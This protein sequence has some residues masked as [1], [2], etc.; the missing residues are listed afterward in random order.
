MVGGCVRDHLMG[1]PLY[2]W[3]IEV[4]GLAS[5]SLQDLLA[6]SGRVSLVGKSFGVF[7]WR[8]PRWRGPEIDV[9]IPRRDSKVGPGHRGI[10]AE[11]DPHLSIEEA[12]RRRDLT[13]NSM[14]VD[15]LTEAIQDPWNGRKDLEDGVLRAVDADTFLE[16]PLRAIRVVQFAARLGFQADTALVDLCRSAALD[17]LPA[18]RIWMEWRKLLL[19]RRPSLGFQFAET[20]AILDR[21]FPEVAGISTE[22]VSRTLDALAASH[23]DGLDPVGRQL[24]LMLVGWLHDGPP[25]SVEATLD[26]LGLHRLGRYDARTAVLSAVQ[27]LSDP[28]ATESDLRWLATRAE[29][30]LVLTVRAASEDVADVMG[31]ARALGVWEA[32]PAPLVQGRD[33]A[34]LG[35]PPGPGMGQLLQ[36]LYAKQLEGDLTSREAALRQAAAWVADQS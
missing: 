32:A 22:R 36:K 6:G 20:A 1:Q 19:S 18:E 28:I 21:V 5:E 30:G 13:I 14:L 3:D 26:R 33:L 2:D 35:F 17:E 29:V 9:S 4:H 12:S 34:G 7:K 24:A 27:H 23:R 11:G 15:L 10:R 31:R 16:D 25:G 8:P